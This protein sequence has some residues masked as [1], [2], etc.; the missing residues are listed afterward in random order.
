MVKFITDETLTS[1]TQQAK[2][3]PRLRMNYNFHSELEDP[4]QRLCN[5]MEPGTY[6]RPHRHA[7]RWEFLSILSGSALAL[8][9]NDDG[10]VIQ[11]VELSARGPVYALELPADTWHT[12]T[13]L[14]SG[15]ILFEVKQGPYIKPEE[16]DFAAWAPAERD[17]AAPRFYDWFLQAS[18]GSLPPLLEE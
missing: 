14:E 15:S 17:A 7:Q 13:G 6:V 3:S 5:A 1:L 4:V 9:F 8:V 11:R 18:A 12:L 16:K 2:Q 10:R